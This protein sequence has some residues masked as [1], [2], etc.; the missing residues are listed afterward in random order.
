MLDDSEF[1][2]THMEHPASDPMPSI[3]MTVVDAGRPAK[4]RTDHTNTL[5][6]HCMWSASGLDNK[7]CQLRSIASTTVMLML[8]IG[9][10]AGCSM[11]VPLN[12]DIV[13]HLPLGCLCPSR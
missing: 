7:H 12:S 2:G 5:P 6:R 13:Q 9:S 10:E 4:D 8:G 11:C 3:N 1:K